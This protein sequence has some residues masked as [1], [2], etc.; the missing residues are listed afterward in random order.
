[1]RRVLVVIIVYPSKS[2]VTVRRAARCLKPCDRI[3]SPPLVMFSHLIIRVN[4]ISRGKSQIDVYKCIQNCIHM[5]TLY[6]KLYTNAD[7]IVYNVYI[8]IQFCIQLCIQCIHMYTYVYICIQN[9]IHMQSSVMYSV[10]HSPM[11]RSKKT[12]C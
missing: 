3:S 12:Y 11:Y 10:M 8:C 1:M 4:N 5:Y 6:T 9:C 2:R 7:K